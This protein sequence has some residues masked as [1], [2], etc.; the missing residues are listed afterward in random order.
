MVVADGVS[1]LQVADFNGDGV[2]D[3]AVAGPDGDDVTVS[4][5]I[6]DG[7]GQFMSVSEQSLPRATSSHT[8]GYFPRLATG[9]FDGDS[10]PDLALHGNATVAS[11]PWDADSLGAP[12]ETAV[13]V[14]SPPYGGAPPYTLDAFAAADFDEDGLEDLAIEI[15]AGDTGDPTLVVLSGRDDGGFDESGSAPGTGVST[16]YS[17]A[18]L[19][20]DGHEDLVGSA[21]DLVASNANLV[22]VLGTGD[23]LFGDARTYLAGPQ[24]Y[25]V[26]AITDFDGDGLLDVVSVAGTGRV[27]ALIGYGDGS[28]GPPIG[29]DVP[30]SQRVGVTAGADFNN[31]GWSD[32]AIS[33]GGNLEILLN[34]LAPGDQVPPGTLEL[35]ASRVEIPATLRRLRKGVVAYG[36]C[37]PDCQLIG[38]I[39]VSRRSA[40]KLGLEEPL[41]V[42]KG[43][44]WGDKTSKLS[45]FPGKTVRRA[46]RKYRGRPLRVTV[47]MRAESDSIRAGETVHSEQKF[48]RTVRAQ[49]PH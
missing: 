30:S 47:I 28:F 39:R 43:A 20:D 12:V 31:D 24:G 29:E 33:R 14:P 11:I 48:A 7:S 49:H 34:D 44:I 25:T 37:R 19:N 27:K 6:G 22:T 9:D 5:L 45:I 21:T 2:T 35:E 16:D 36:S 23:G 32:I 1:D 18:D 3:L 13:P 40:R 26:P 46:F 8:P 17:V 38:E 4:V 41:L 42:S 10:D 15:H